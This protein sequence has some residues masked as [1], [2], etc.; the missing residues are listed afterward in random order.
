MATVEEIEA[1]RRMVD[2]PTQDPYTD[3]TLS[4]YIDEA[5]SLDGAA[6][7]VWQEKAAKASTLV[8]TSESGSSRSLGQ[9]HQNALNMAK[10]YSARAG[11][12]EVV[13]ISDAPFTA[14]IERS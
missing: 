8:N 4:A 14:A 7:E 10:F 11:T 1:L 5:G 3:A 13:D 6:A 9:I 12:D 2:E